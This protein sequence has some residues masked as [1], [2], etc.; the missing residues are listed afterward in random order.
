VVPQHPAHQ[1]QS[2]SPI[3][4]FTPSSTVPPRGRRSN[5]IRDP[6]EGG[7]DDDDEDGVSEL[8][9]ED[10]GTGGGEARA[11]D[12]FGIGDDE[13]SPVLK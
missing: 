1:S 8:E 4:S 6:V 13:G 2:T 9:S 5:R 12:M 10:H 3:P 7:D 11:G